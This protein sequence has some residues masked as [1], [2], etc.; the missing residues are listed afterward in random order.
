[1]STLILMPALAAACEGGVRSRSDGAGSPRYSSIVGYLRDAPVSIEELEGKGCV[2]VTLAA[3]R[4][5]ALA[6]S[7]DG[8][9]LLW[10][11]PRLSDAEIVKTAP[12]KLVGGL[13]GDRLWFSPEVD[14]HWD[15]APDWREFANY[16][17][18]AASDPGAYAFVKVDAAAVGLHAKG[19][20]T[21]HGSNQSV[22]FDVRRIVR[23]IKP[24]QSISDHLMRGVDYV[25]I[26]TT[27]TLKLEDTVNAGWMDLWHLMQVPVDSVLIVP[28]NSKAPSKD[29]QPLSYGLP[30]SWIAKSDHIVWKFGGQAR[31]KFGLA[32]A[33]STGRAAILRHLGEDRWCLIVRQFPTDPKAIYGDHPYGVPR[34]DQV[35]QAWDGFGFGEMEYHSPLLDVHRGPRELQES[36]Q[37]WAFGGSAR[38][39]VAI[40]AQ[41]LDVDIAYLVQGGSA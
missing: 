24:P 21:S 39:I 38:A 27:H 31:A 20:L 40:A 5:V 9:N 4:V 17:T 26:E 22:E 11:N 32:A 41:L 28:L 15:G 7:K 12:E 33:A 1:M 2:A 25:G 16:K 3:G 8:L 6:F 36:D 19:V 23:M 10:S 18:P 37:V 30:G 29:R 13:G 35:F 14:Y 34:R